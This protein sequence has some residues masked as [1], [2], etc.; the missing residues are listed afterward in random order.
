MQLVQLSVVIELTT[1]AV[2]PAQFIGQG[3]QAPLD[4]IKPLLQT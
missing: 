4:K 2:H 3:K 1:T